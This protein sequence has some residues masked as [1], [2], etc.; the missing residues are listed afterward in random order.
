L[1][2]CCDS[3]I[4]NL[5]TQFCTYYDYKIYSKCDG[6]EYNTQN[7]RCQSDVLEIKCGVDWYDRSRYCVDG[8]VTTVKG[9]FIDARDDKTYEYVTIGSQTW[10]AKNLNYDMNGSVCKDPANCNTY[11]RLYNWATAKTACP[12]K[13]H[14]P[15]R[16]EW[17]VLSNYVT[18]RSDK[19][20][21]VEG[22]HLGAT[23]WGGLDTYG[24]AAS[25]DWWWSASE[26][27]NDHPY[28]RIAHHDYNGAEIWHIWYGG[29]SKDE[30][31]SV[32]CVKD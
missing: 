29:I 16:D 18:G 1:H 26:Y 7:Q 22:M 17:N 15:T 2:G 21:S 30:L 27:L 14:L 23:S 3:K 6:E 9:K 19:N 5:A 28:G 11:G 8:A 13:W 24:F 25:P 12:S 20:P 10:M 32:R 31:C 4:Y